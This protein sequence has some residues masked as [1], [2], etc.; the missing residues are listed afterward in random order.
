MR[1]SIVTVC[2]NSVETIERAIKSVIGQD[3]DDVEYIVIDG[4]STDGTVDVIKKYEQ[5][6]SYWISEED[7]GIYDAMNKGIEHSTGDVIAFL[8]SDDWYEDNILGEIARR[9]KEPEMQIL[10]G[11]IYSHW[12]GRVERSHIDKEKI[13]QD[14]RYCMGYHHSAMF[15]RKK[16]FLQFGKFDTQFKIVADYDWLLRVYDGH[17]NIIVVDKVFTNFSCGG[18]SSRYEMQNQHLQERKKASLLSLERSVE[19]NDK[20]KHIW[21][22]VIEKKCIEDGYSYKYAMI[23]DS[24]LAGRE[25]DMLTYVKRAFDQNKYEVFGCGVCFRELKAIMEKLNI[26][27]TRLWDN[28]NEKWGTLIDGIMVGNPDD[29]LLNEDMVIVASTVNEKEIEA[30][31]IGKGF[32]KNRHY[33]LY[34][35]QIKRMVDLV[36]MGM[37]YV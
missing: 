25:K 6:I 30:Q 20:E 7:G 24:V 26:R 33:L 16:L 23:L 37:G 29:M 27:I 28:N 32:R 35:E 22:D 34:S 13:E 2:Y 18:I 15:V 4:G 11:N 21:S 3:Y 17:I 14:I 19:L 36:D 12:K 1:I 31:L 8:N 5:N 10:C 9:F